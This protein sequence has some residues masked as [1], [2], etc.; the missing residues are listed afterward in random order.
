MKSVRRF[1]E[2]A[3]IDSTRPENRD[4]YPSEVKCDP[5]MNVLCEIVGAETTLQFSS[6]IMTPRRILSVK[7]SL[8]RYNKNENHATATV[9]S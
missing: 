6:R 5:L 4:D 8:Y 3:P 7:I 2:A 9:G 1:V